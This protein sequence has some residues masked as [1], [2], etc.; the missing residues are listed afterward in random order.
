[1][2][3]R[4]GIVGGGQLGRMLALAGKPLG[5]TCTVID[6]A[7]DAGAAIA[8]KHIVAAF[9]D[10][11]ALGQLADQSDVVTFEFENVP[12]PAL[13]AIARRTKIAPPASALE[14]SQDRLTEKQLF[15]SIGVAT[16]PHAAV[17]S[18]SELEDAAA[19]LGLPAILKTRTLGYDGK[20]QTRV[21][22]ESGLHH[23]WEIVGEAPSILEAVVDFRR[24]LSVIAARSASGEIAIY[25]L[26]ENVHRA[27]IL[28][29]STAPAPDVSDAVRATARDYVTRLLEALDYVGV[30][31]LEL[32]DTT[33]GL[34]ANE[35]A[36][37][38][39]NSGHWTIDAAPTSQ[40]ENHLRAVLGMPLGATEP[41]TPC[42]MLNLIGGA[43]DAGA[44][45]AVP[46]AHLHMYDKQPRP[47]RKIGHITVT[48]ID[49]DGDA[50]DALAPALAVL[51]PLVADAAR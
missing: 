40:F 39:H 17:S 16:A 36:P 21:E 4:V 23:A 48:A 28:R 12:A 37:R 35:F 20:G 27:G 31:A 32:F 22:S 47:G 14:V 50:E 9:D 11:D 7:P 24:E 25:P 26:T 30:L 51:E 42:V 29:R 41:A 13:E 2:A 8:A 44:V 6:P 45:N 38:V 5:I 49:G 19:A 1:V 3:T 46:G 34:V 33:E 15:E 18:Q 10:I 43:P